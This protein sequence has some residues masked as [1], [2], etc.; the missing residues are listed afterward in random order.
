MPSRWATA[1]AGSG[2]GR[3]GDRLEHVEGAATDDS[4]SFG[5]RRGPAGPDANRVAGP[6]VVGAGSLPSLRPDARAGR[7]PDALRL[8][9]SRAAGAA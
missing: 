9:L 7:S 8:S 5:G 1:F 6:R 2:V 3:L 4:W